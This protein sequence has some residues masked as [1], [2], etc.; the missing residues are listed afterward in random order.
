M[1]SQYGAMP[2]GKWSSY[3]HF[4]L[5]ISGPASAP[6]WGQTQDLST[7]IVSITPQ[8][9]HW[10]DPGELKHGSCSQAITRGPGLP[11]SARKKGGKGGEGASMLCPTEPVLRP[12]RTPFAWRGST[13]K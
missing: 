5:Y 8:C 3:T 1:S 6:V 9:S 2:V 10:H 11:L 7:H 4:Y 12:P 13:L